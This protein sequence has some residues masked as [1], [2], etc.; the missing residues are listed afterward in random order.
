ME[1]VEGPFL[2]GAP[3]HAH[4]VHTARG[5]CT[6]SNPRQ[7]GLHQLCSDFYGSFMQ[8]GLEGARGQTREREGPAP[9]QQNQGRMR[10]LREAA[11][12]G[13]GNSADVARR[14]GGREGGRSRRIFRIPL[15]GPNFPVHH[16]PPAPPFPP[17]QLC[18]EIH[19]PLYL[20]SLT[21]SDLCNWA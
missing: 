11:G 13:L 8:D 5:C 15:I 16:P 18:F 9:E 21:H 2:T 7:K 6:P 4:A 1:T 17:L 12:T 10:G 19:Y 20:R 14:E 3:A